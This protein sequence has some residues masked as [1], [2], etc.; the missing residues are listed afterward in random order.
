MK[1]IICFIA[2]F[3]L[4]G[5]TAS[6]EMVTKMYTVLIGE[7]ANGISMQCSRANPPQFTD[8]WVPDDKM[9]LSVE[10]NLDKIEHLAPNL[11]CL[12]NVHISNV[13]GY[14]RQYVGIISEGRRL[15]YIN[16]FRGPNTRKN[17]LT[18]PV[19]A[20]D[21]GTSFWGAIFDPDTGEFSQLAINGV[22]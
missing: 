1:T 4:Q 17:W 12:R 2:L 16:A 7:E 21:G 15:I 19:I 9:V 5:A 3:T 22:A 14:F 20:C 8:T 13:R 11:C 6:S 18:A 10:A